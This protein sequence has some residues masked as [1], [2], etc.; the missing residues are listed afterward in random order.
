MPYTNLTQKEKSDLNASLKIIDKYVIRSI[1]DLSGNIIDV[2]K[3]FCNIS[4]YTKEELIGK[5]HSI[6]RHPDM[7]ASVFKKLWETIKSGNN[8]VGEIKNRAKDGTSY[9]VEAHIEPNFEK[10]KIVS[11]T[12]IRTDITDRILLE[13]L[14]KSLNKKIKIEVEKS[15]Q[16]LELIQQEQLKSVKLSSIGALTAGITH[17][18]NTPLTYIKGNFELMK[19]DLEDL[20]QNEIRDRILEDTE[21]ITSGIDRISNIVEAMREVSQSSTESREKINIYH[22]LRTALIVSNNRINQVTRIYINGNLYNMDLE[23]DTYSFFSTVQKQRIE[24]VWIIIINNA[25]DELVKIVEYEDRRLDINIFYENSKVIVEFKDNAGGI[26]KKIL[27]K[28]FEPFVSSK[29]SGGVGIGLNVAK[30]IVEENKGEIFARN[31]SNGAVF[32]I[33]LS[34]EGINDT[35]E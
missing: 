2:S 22:T 10:G 1:V 33:E 7:D 30:K 19:Y 14:N 8:W 18:I 11:Y 35:R 25:L 29:K 5:P 16:Q 15:T 31:A 21:V 4:K 34:A 27:T 13:D 24:Q 28:I 26:P 9:W 32:R 6:V 23:K 12:A 20:P 3:A 17:E